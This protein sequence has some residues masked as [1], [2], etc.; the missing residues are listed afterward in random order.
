MNKEIRELMKKIP[1]AQKKIVKK[2]ILLSYKEGV[3]DS[4]ALINQIRDII[5]DI[6]P[7]NLKGYGVYPDDSIDGG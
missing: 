7:E 5:Q 2:I 1:T 3:L 4:I 6:N